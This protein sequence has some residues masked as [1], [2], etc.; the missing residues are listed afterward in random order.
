LSHHHGVGLLRSPYMR[1]SLGSGFAVLVAIKKAL[2]PKNIL[3]PGKL[4]L[5]DELLHGQG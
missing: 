1:E 5:G 3:N 4:G 2:D